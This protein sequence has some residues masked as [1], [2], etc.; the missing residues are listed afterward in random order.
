MAGSRRRADSNE[1]F[2]HFGLE[3]VQEVWI[4]RWPSDAW[5]LR[6]EAV[7]F[8]NESIQ[9]FIQHACTGNLW[10]PQAWA[11]DPGDGE[12]D[13][14]LLPFEELNLVSQARRDGGETLELGRVCGVEKEQPRNKGVGCDARHPVFPKVL[15]STCHSVDVPFLLPHST[16]VPPRA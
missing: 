4:L 11:R 2:R 16:H 13:V 10:P 9:V 15:D 5:G 1:N 3:I 6:K 14:L 8:G 7:S 12:D